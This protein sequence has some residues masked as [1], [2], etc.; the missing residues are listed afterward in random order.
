MKSDPI[1]IKEHERASSIL[2]PNQVVGKK[3]NVIKF[4]K[5]DK[6]L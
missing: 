6:Q 1:G 5:K 3:I 2:S 4:T